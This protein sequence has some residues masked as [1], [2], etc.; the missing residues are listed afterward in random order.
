MERLSER[1]RVFSIGKSALCRDI[2]AV[3][4]G[5]APRVLF[6]GAI[7]AREWVTAPLL[8]MLAFDFAQRLYN[9]T[10][11]TKSG[12]EFCYTDVAFVPMLNPDGCELCA[13]GVQS[14]P[15][16][17]R[18]TLKLINGGGDFSLWKANAKGVDLNVNF[19]AH[20]G[21]GAENV[22]CPSSQS[23]VGEQPFSESE[24]RAI[25]RFSQ[26]SRVVLAYHTKGEE[27]Y[28]GFLDDRSHRIWAQKLGDEL[29]YA[30]KTSDGSAG[31]F[32]DWF[33]QN[34]MGLALTVECGSDDLPHPI[35]EEQLPALFVK[36]KNVAAL[37]VQICNEMG[38]E[39][40]KENFKQN[41]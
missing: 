14:V 38:E 1:G 15:K 5:E 27:I 20:W 10:G 41:R 32:K 33:V 24:S 18:K 40:A 39:L 8:T 23:Y 2:W 36:H 16:H 22:F 9:K 17:M 13:R 7:H 28:Y 29:G 37:A 6:F 21:E 4:F 3:Q 31:G 30:V 12:R 34:K 25:A 26:N 11:R 35:G 19:D